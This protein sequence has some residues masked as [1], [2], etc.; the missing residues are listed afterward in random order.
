M[1]DRFERNVCRSIA[2]STNSTG[3]IVAL[4]FLFF[5]QELA[6]DAVSAIPD[7][8]SSP[9]QR[10]EMSARCLTNLITVDKNLNDNEAL[11]EHLNRLEPLVRQFSLPYW[12]FCY[13]GERTLVA[14]E[15]GDFDLALK[16]NGE[17]IKVS[18]FHENLAKIAQKKGYSITR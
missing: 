14:K 2:Q 17:A 15:K 11:L 9:Q 3:I 10:A 12:R 4:A 5:L 16:F 6:L 8:W 7:R 13:F 18:K 1:R